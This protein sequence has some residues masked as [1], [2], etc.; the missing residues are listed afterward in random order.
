MSPWPLMKT[1]GSAILSV[2]RSSRWE[3]ETEYR[4][5]ALAMRCPE[6]ASV[7]LDQLAADRQPDAQTVG[8][9]RIERLENPLQIAFSDAGAAVRDFHHDLLAI[10]HA[11]GDGDL[12]RAARWC[13]LDRL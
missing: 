12:S 4:A 8:L 10:L 6:L 7:R 3:C 11:K 9:G 5:A 2:Y 13:A 1:M